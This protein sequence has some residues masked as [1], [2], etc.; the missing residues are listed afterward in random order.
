MNSHLV[1]AQRLLLAALAATSLLTTAATAQNLLTNGSFEQPNLGGG[2]GAVASGSGLPGWTVIGAGVDHAGSAWQGAEGSAQSLSLGWV[3]DAGVTQTVSTVP[4]ALYRLRF[5]MAA[6]VY[7]GPAVRTMDVSW[8]G[9]TVDSV[10]FQYTGQGPTTMGWELHE[11]VLVGTGSDTLTF[12]S[13]TGSNYGPALDA[14]SL[15]GLAP[16]TYCTPKTNSQ[17]CVPQISSVGT[18]SATNAGGFSVD[19]TNVLSGQHGVLF[20]GYAEANVPF[21]G[22]TLCVAAPQVR[23]GVQFSGGNLGGLDCS[24]A[25]S[26]DFN[27]HIAS[28]V[29]PALVAGATVYCQ[30][31]QRDP[32]DAT[33]Y[34][35]T[36]GLRFTIAP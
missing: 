12:M 28:G 34:G 9:S 6:E 4:G 13:T 25:Y 1:G 7:G 35:F 22:G 29:D 15:E 2:W 33:G 3:S 11:Y 36:G 26:F 17:G 5:H 27:A 31:W 24:G 21:H 20:Y 19:A 16:E 32:Q 8:N 30:Y 14:V 10:I 18:P 23:T